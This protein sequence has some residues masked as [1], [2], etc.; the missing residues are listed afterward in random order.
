LNDTVSYSG[1]HNEANGESNN[2]GSSDV[3]WNCGEEGPT[4]N[5]TI[6]QQRRKQRRNMLATVL[7]SQGVPM[8]MAGDEFGRTQGGNNN[9]YCQD[10]NVSWVDWEREER[11]RDMVTFVKELVRLRLSNPV[12]RRTAF[13]EGLVHPDSSLKDVTWLLEDGTEMLEADW[14]DARRQALGVLFDRSGA[15]RSRYHAADASEAGDSFLLLFNASSQDK[16]FRVP[17]P[18]GGEAWEPVFDTQEETGRTS[19]LR[20]SGGDNYV[21]RQCSMALLV[22]RA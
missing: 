1:K 22:D 15:V 16:E 18:I 8:I 20:L 2:D 3:C 5:Q 9:A 21:V 4:E 10:N 12:F 13:L 6:E 17:A 11:D 19:H 7:L 14:N